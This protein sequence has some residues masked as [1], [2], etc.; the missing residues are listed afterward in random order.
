MRDN[1]TY[2]LVKV[3][4]AAFLGVAASNQVAWAAD[5]T[6]QMPEP[7]PVQTESGWTFSF[8]PYF[9]AAGLSGTT[10]QFGLPSIEIDSSFSDIFSNLD[11]AFM[12]AGEARYDRFSIIGDMMYSKLS[13][14]AHTPNG[15]LASTV[16]VTSE[17]FIGLLGVGYSVLEDSAGHLDVVGGVKVWSVNTD[18]SFDGGLLDGVERSDGATWVDGVVG[19]RGTYS[20]T[21]KIYLTGWGLVGG[22]G[23]DIDWDVALGLGYKFG[24]TVSAL[25][26]YRALGV[27]YSRDGFVYD[28]VQQG[29]ILGVS[30]RF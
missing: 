30:I 10:K 4:L 8:A 1:R 18:I 29:P 12:A 13:A 5:M 17:S 24:D 26:G 14:D 3:S 16:D 28:A 7:V 2:T 20:L 25:A 27:D 19:L 23:A 11:F 15:I 6:G 22:G 9:W 21:Q